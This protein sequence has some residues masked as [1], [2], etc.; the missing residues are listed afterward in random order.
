[1]NQLKLTIVVI[2]FNNPKEVT[3]TLSSIFEQSSDN[4]LYAEVLIVYSYTCDEYKLNLSDKVLDDWAINCCINE[5]DGIYSAMNIGIRLARGEYIYFLNSGDYFRDRYSLDNIYCDLRSDLD[6]L[7]YCTE[8]R[9]RNLAM[10]RHVVNKR[11]QD[12]FTPGHQGVIAKKDFLIKE[13][14]YFHEA[15]GLGSDS[16]WIQEIMERMN[17]ALVSNRVIAVFM[18][19]GS[20][21]SFSFSEATIRF[22]TR[23]MG[24]FL[25]YLTKGILK[26]LIPSLLY[27]RLNAWFR[28]YKMVKI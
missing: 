21:N 9:F 11:S 2:G 14:I 4:K 15:I 13:G 25:I 8:Q 10:I 3:L 23:S 24:I 1:M 16:L 5:D 18:L 26:S 27:W 19:D 6:V 28:G 20:S 17:A 12:R 7:L 22:R